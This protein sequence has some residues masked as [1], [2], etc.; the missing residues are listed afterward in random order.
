[1]TCCLREAGFFLS[2]SGA[3][4]VSAFYHSCPAAL[5]NPRRVE[6]EPERGIS[7]DEKPNCKVLSCCQ[8]AMTALMYTAQP[9]KRIKPALFEILQIIKPKF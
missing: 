4:D 7:Y 3:P 5:F 6:P 1:M 2:N 9:W 8:S